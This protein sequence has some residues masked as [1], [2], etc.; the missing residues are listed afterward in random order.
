MNMLRATCKGNSAGHITPHW[1]ILASTSAARRHD[2]VT[3]K[4]SMI[5][6]IMVWT[7]VWSLEPR[8]WVIRLARPSTNS[9]LARFLVTTC[10][11]ACRCRLVAICMLLQ[12]ATSPSRNTRSQGTSTLSKKATASISSKREPRGWSK[13]E[14]LRSKL[15][16]HWNFSPGV[17][18]GMAKAK[19]VGLG[20]LFGSMC[21]A[22]GY[23]AISSESGARVASTR[24]P[25]TIIP[26]SV[27][28]TTDRA[29]SVRS[30]RAVAPGA[31]LRCRF[32]RVWVRTR[33]FSRICS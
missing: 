10:C 2:R 16:R 31:R 14:R 26:A 22:V 6:A 27:S 7:W 30:S 29:K 25:W 23:R 5:S 20:A 1:S 24:A 21:D 3:S 17:S 18:Q 8:V 9:H 32:K 15:S 33:S 4:F 11:P 12:R 28:L 13:W 19:D